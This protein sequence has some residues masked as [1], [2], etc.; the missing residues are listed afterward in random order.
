MPEY[1]RVAAFEVS[2]ASGRLGEA[3]AFV[4]RAHARAD[5]GGDIPQVRKG[6]DIPYVGHLLQ[7]AGLVL[8]HG[9]TLDHAVAALLHDSLEDG[10]DVTQTLLADRFGPGVARIVADCS[11]T[12]ASPGGGEKP[13]WRERKQ[14]Y[15][16]HLREARADSALVSACDKLQNLTAM[17]ADLRREGIKSM[18]R[19]NAP[20]PEQ[21][22]F[23]REV[24][25]AAADRL[26]ASLRL[27]YERYLTEF[28]AL[29]EA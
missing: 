1:K 18:E 6:T 2:A 4:I 7:V 17:I 22:W 12:V 28:A 29:L 11:D 15:I 13:P 26:P 21:L 24:L 27:R 8:D 3:L 14:R 20:P 10:R 16:D 9:G 23:Y 5:S 19:F 25:A